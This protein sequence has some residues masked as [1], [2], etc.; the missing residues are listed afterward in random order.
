MFHP[1]SSFSVN[2]VATERS[3]ES[4]LKNLLQLLR[5]T[6]SIHKIDEWTK[7]HDFKQHSC[8]LK[9]FTSSGTDYVSDE[10]SASV[11]T[12]ENINRSKLYMQK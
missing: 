6:A 5:I 10:P 4:R 12:A 9:Q 2:S 3:D 1:S 7:N 11:L 8:I